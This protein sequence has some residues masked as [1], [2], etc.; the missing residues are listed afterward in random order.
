MKI[1]ELLEMLAKYDPET[2]IAVMD[3]EYGKI[4]EIELEKECGYLV[5]ECGKSLLE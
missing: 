3:E 1:K 2:P 4:C 5:I